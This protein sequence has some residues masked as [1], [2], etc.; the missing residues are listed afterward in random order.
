MSN[1]LE[2]H[3]FERQ[4][5]PPMNFSILSPLAPRIW[6]PLVLGVGVGGVGGWGQKF[7]LCGI[8]VRV[9]ELVEPVLVL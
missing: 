4:N 6:V 2:H 9:T 8:R 1:P 3:C 7:V 5:D